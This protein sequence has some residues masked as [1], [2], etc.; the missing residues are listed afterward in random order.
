[1]TTDILASAEAEL[2]KRIDLRTARIT[3]TNK[4]LVVLVQGLRGGRS[5]ERC[6]RVYYDG[7]WEITGCPQHGVSARLLVNDNPVRGGG[8]LH[9]GDLQR[10][11]AIMRVAP[12]GGSK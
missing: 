5:V 3:H 9:R 1:M 11:A 10:I 7:R 6:L 4:C 8:G 12:A 2:R